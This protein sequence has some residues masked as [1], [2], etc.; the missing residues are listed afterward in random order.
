MRFAA[1]IFA[2]TLTPA[3]LAA[4]TKTDLLT[5]L[6]PLALQEK[7]KFEYRVDRQH[8]GRA[9]LHVNQEEFEGRVK[10][11]ATAK[12]VRSVSSRGT[13]SGLRLSI[14]DSEGNK[15]PEAVLSHE[16]A[17]SLVDPA[18]VLLELLPHLAIQSE[19]DEVRDGRAVR[20]VVL[21]PPNQ[22][23][24][25]ARKGPFALLEVHLWLDETNLPVAAEYAGRLNFGHLL[26]ASQ[27]AFHTYAVENGRLITTEAR[28][29]GEADGPLGTRAKDEV[30]FRLQRQ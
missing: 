15:E 27:R 18:G 28:F 22:E 21:G 10:I 12:G 6:A 1:T 17:E 23:R 9:P 14:W 25:V 2:L 3:A 19:R 7:A 24:P 29:V 5:Q 20:H 8:D 13:S 26:Q 16:D 4:D 30:S 11:T